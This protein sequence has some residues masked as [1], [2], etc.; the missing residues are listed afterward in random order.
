MSRTKYVVVHMLTM[1]QGLSDLLQQ[2]EVLERHA[3]EERAKHRQQIKLAS[4]NS[5]TST[6]FKNLLTSLVAT[7]FPRRMQL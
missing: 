6:Q 3:H 2:V 7:V 4:Y 5:L 1:K